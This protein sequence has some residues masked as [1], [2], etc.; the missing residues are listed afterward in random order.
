MSAL[1]SMGVVQVPVRRPVRVAMVV[2]G[3]ELVGTDHHPQPW[4]IRESHS[5]AV[6]CALGTA[7]WIDLLRT[8]VVGDDLSLIASTV[9]ASVECDVVLLTGGV[10]MGDRDFVPDVVR[11]AGGEIIFH[12]LALRP[13]RPTLRR[14]RSQWAGYIRAAGESFVGVGDSAQ[15]GGH[16]ARKL[17]GMSEIDPPSPRVAVEGTAKCHPVYRLFPPAILKPQGSAQIVE[18][19]NSGDLI[20]A[21]QTDGFVEIPPGDSAPSSVSFHSWAL[22]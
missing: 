22:T 15:A 18:A 5:C 3:D 9:A 16:C 21:A 17:A 6:R 8:T 20:A 2:T 19:K 7:P 12:G 10:S 4:Q 1:A 13:G 11:Q 14:N